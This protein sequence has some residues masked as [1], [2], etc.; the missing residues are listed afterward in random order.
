M[1]TILYN[2]VEDSSTVPSTY[3]PEFV[4][5]AELGIEEISTLINDA[6]PTIP[7]DAITQIIVG[8]SNVLSW[9]LN[10]G[11]WAAIDD[12][13]TWYSDI[14]TLLAD[15]TD[16]I[17]DDDFEPVVDTYDSFES[18]IAEI[19]TYEL[20]DIID[21]AIPYISS[22]YASDNV[23]NYVGYLKGLYVVGERF[24]INNAKPDEGVFLESVSGTRTK[25]ERVSLSSSTMYLVTSLPTPEGPGGQNSVEFLLSIS[26]RLTP[27]A[28]VST[29]TYGQPIRAL[30]VIVEAYRKVFLSA[31]ED[32][33]A[34]IMS[35]NLLAG[36][37]LT[38]FAVDNG[39]AIDIYTV[40]S[41]G[42]EGDRVSVASNGLYVVQV[43]ASNEIRLQVKDINNISNKI[44]T[45][46]GLFFDVLQVDSQPGF[47]FTTIN[48]GGTPFDP[49]ISKTGTAVDWD[50]GDGTI[51][52]ANNSVNYSGYTD[53]TT[54]TVR[55][56][57][58]DSI[59]LI[60]VISMDSDQ[61]TGSMPDLSGCTALEEC[62]L[63]TNSMTGEISSLSNNTSIVNFDCYS[64][65]LTGS[66]P[67]LTSNA[68]LEYISCSSNDLTG[69]IPDL[70]GNALLEYFLSTSNEITGYEGGLDSCTALLLFNVSNN[71]LTQSAVSDI[72]DDLWIIR[73]S[74]GALSCSINIGGSGNSIPDAEAIAKIEGTGAYS[75]DGLKDAGCTVVYN[76]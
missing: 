74:I 34:E 21:P 35:H 69:A 48:D 59:P 70:S 45:Y 17:D 11:N 68:A 58:I 20:N 2:A 71:L 8:F 15:Y 62:Y 46:K 73:S 3:T 23:Q 10:W 37:D 49:S 9:Q 6:N 57:N 42:L 67:D 38:I 61:I 75:G 7:V 63:N 16:D 18:E 47:A 76:T 65:Q 53:S 51:I 14:S 1:P 27:T 22:S 30:N 36:T 29:G 56:F 55:I 28:L 5:R 66:I 50:L 12:F 24:N 32:D 19:A 60:T 33:N 13:A 43:G 64:N 4:E 52:T 25:Q 31:L 44:D 72:I 41:D 40:D 39:A 54:K 26:I